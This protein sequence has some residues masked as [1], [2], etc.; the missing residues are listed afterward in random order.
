[1]CQELVLNPIITLKEM[2]S[3]V[4]TYGIDFDNIL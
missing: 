1:M 3:S 4:Y 2:I